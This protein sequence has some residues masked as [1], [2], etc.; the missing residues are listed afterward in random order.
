MHIGHT[1]GL[2]SGFPR[3]VDPQPAWPRRGRLI[4]GSRPQW[5]APRILGCCVS[6]ESPKQPGRGFRLAQPGRVGWVAPAAKKDRKCHWRPSSGRR[7]AMLCD[8]GYGQYSQL[9]LS[10]CPLLF[11]SQDNQKYSV[12]FKMSWSCQGVHVHVRPCIA[13]SCNDAS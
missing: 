13:S 12:S 10:A 2:S 7:W 6:R 5:V 4:P 11:N 1:R 3:G 8:L 9:L